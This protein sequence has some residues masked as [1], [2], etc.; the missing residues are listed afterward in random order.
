[1]AS[2]KSKDKASATTTTTMITLTKEEEQK[3]VAFLKQES[4]VDTKQAWGPIPLLVLD[5]FNQALD[6]HYD[7]HPHGLGES[8]AEVECGG[9][10]N[11]SP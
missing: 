11:A 10:E 5:R 6:T 4:P 3:F 7:G 8:I 2:A 9:L 1:M